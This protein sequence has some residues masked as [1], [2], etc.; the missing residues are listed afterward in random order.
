MKLLWTFVAPPCSQGALFQGLEDKSPLSGP[1]GKDR[2]ILGEKWLLRD[3]QNSSS[4]L[5]GDMQTLRHSSALLHN[6]PNLDSYSPQNF[7][8]HFL[9]KT[10]EGTRVFIIFISLWKWGFSGTI[11]LKSSFHL[12]E[13]A[14]YLSHRKYAGMPG[15][16]HTTII[17]SLKL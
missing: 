6:D 7:P 15:L 1:C 12:R 11:C 2:T 8:K 17:K 9:L 5:E 14:S 3:T 4:S 10:K 16:S 13:T